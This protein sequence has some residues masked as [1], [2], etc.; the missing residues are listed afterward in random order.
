L[1]ALAMTGL[2]ECREPFEPLG[3]PAVHVSNTNAYRHPEGADPARMLASLLAE[4][5]ETIAREGAET[6]AMLIAEPV[7]N[8]GGCLVP[9]D[10][11]WQGLRELCDRHGILLVSDEVIC[12]FG[13]LGTF[14]GA[15]RLGYKPDM[16]TIAK[17]LTGAH[18]PM[19]AVLISERV[20]EPFIEGKT[21][22]MHGITFGGHPVGAAVARKT[23]E[24]YERDGVMENVMAN[25][26]VLRDSLNALRDIPI[27]G[28][29]RGMGH[30][31]AIEL[32]RDQESKLTFE[33]PAAEW[34]LK[35]VLSAELWGRGMICRLD[36]RTEPIVQIAPPLVTDTETIEEIAQILRESLEVAAERMSERPEFT[37][38]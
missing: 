18:F 20:A 22:Y 4:V 24:I 29:V 30:F 26:S 27:V 25:E 16:I 31:W 33:G 34:L 35:D 21:M 7:Q 38:A 1:G 8:A 36:D 9:P 37:A 17:G 6:I 11:Y 3:V 10:G 13:R 23:L 12:A 5:E 28:D 14:F 2:A 19:G 15:E 32:V